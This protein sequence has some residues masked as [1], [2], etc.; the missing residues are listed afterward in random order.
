[1]R[2]WIALVVFLT[3]VHAA[4]EQR[5]VAQDTPRQCLRRLIAARAYETVQADVAAANAGPATVSS[6]IRSAVKDFLSVIS[7]HLDQS[8]LNDSG[9]ALT[10][11]YNVP[12]TLLGAIRQMKLETVLTDP[13]LSPGVQAALASDP[14]TLTSLQ[15]NLN[16]ADDVT[17]SLTFNPVTQRLG[18]LVDP[19]RALL[20][21]MVLALVANSGPA[22]GAVPAASFDTPFNQIVPDDAA[23]L[24]AMADFETAATAAMPAAAA[25]LITDFTRLVMNQP[26]LYASA[27]YHQRKQIVGPVERGYRLT[28]EIQTDNL[29]SFRGAEGRDCETKDNCLAAFNDYTTRTAAEHRT[30]RLALA[31][32]YHSTAKN[33]PRLTVNP[34]VEEKSTKLTY[35]VAYGQ[36]VTSFA[37]GKQA[38]IDF[39]LD[40][41]G[42]NTTHGTTVTSLRVARA[43][44]GEISPQSLPASTT[45]LSAASTITQP[46]SDRLSALLSVV[47]TDRAE[48]LPGTSSPPSPIIS[49]SPI[50]N[51]KTQPFSTDQRKVVVHIG[52]L[53]HLPSLSRPSHPSPGCC[54]R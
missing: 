19:N 53:V 8:T 44:F 28:W 24:T 11:D 2:F 25:Q 3:A 5:C 21:S 34:F 1:M 13:E 6:P 37:S 42:K 38:R 4:A 22:I 45:R 40:Y 23:R 29:N 49:P 17:F 30:G 47:W 14:T 26:Q 51:G 35:S 31:I 7:A 16:H 27:I 12:V 10:L 41:D 36:E 52:L 15:H 39:T 9:K 54:C 48:W 46:I 50:G 20:Q 18:R 33:D 43:A 32:E